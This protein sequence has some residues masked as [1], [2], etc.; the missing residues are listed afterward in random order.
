MFSSFITSRPDTESQDLKSSYSK[1]FLCQDHPRIFSTHFAG[2]K[3]PMQVLFL[4]G[5]WLNVPVNSYGH[6]ETVS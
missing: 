5:L 2:S 6:V 3:S 4:F 1:G